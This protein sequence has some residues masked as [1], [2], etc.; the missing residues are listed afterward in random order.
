MYRRRLDAHDQWPPVEPSEHIPLLLSENISSST[1]TEEMIEN[2][3]RRSLVGNVAST[4]S[5]QRHFTINQLFEPTTLS[6]PEIKSVLIEGAPGIGKTAL[7][8]AACQLWAQG[9]VFQHFKMVIRWSLSS[10]I[11]AGVG[12]VNDLIFHDSVA[13][14]LAVVDTVCKSGGKGVLYVLD[15][16]DEL[17]DSVDE[18][19]VT[20][21]LDLVKGKRL[22]L[23]CV[24]VTTRPLQSTK[25]YKLKHAWFD[26]IVEISGFSEQ[27]IQEYISK[28]LSR[29]PALATK[30]LKQLST[31]PDIESICYI[32]L[33]C[34][35]VTY[36]FSRKQLLPK[37]LSEFYKVF[38]LNFLL[39]NM[40]ERLEGGSKIDELGH[41]DC[42]PTPVKKI[43]VGISELAFR[44]LWVSKHMYSRKEFESVF[45][46]S[47]VVVEVDQLGVLQTQTVFH[48]T[49]S[50][51]VF[52]FL[53]SSVQEYLAACYLAR[54]STGEQ[55]LYISKYLL[56]RPLS[57]VWPF[58]SGVAS[59]ITQLRE[60]GFVSQFSEIAE[61]IDSWM[62]YRD[63]F[64][65]ESSLCS[66]YESETDTS[67]S[68]YG[69]DNTPGLEPIQSPCPRLG[70]SCSSLASCS[71]PLS[72]PSSLAI[73]SVQPS[74]AVTTSA[75][76]GTTFLTTS[77]SSSLTSR[78][79]LLSPPSSVVQDSN[80]S[81][82]RIGGS[83]NR[84][85]YSRLLFVLKCLF[86]SQN[87]ALC[88]VVAEGLKGRISLCGRALQRIDIVTIGYFL[89]AVGK[90]FLVKIEDCK[91]RKH[92]LI[93]LDH[94]LKNAFGVIQKLYLG[95]NGLDP[96]SAKEL[97]KMAPTLSHCRTLVLRKNELG[98]EGAEY[99][100]DMLGNLHQ[101]QA[102]D[103]S[104]NHI[105]HVGA[106]HICRSLQL[107]SKLTH[108]H[109]DHN[110][111]GPA[112]AKQIAQAVLDV[113][114][115]QHLSIACTEL[116]DRGVEALA[117]VLGE[118]G[119]LR[120]LDISGNGIT[121]EGAALLGSALTVNSSLRILKFHSNLIG[122]A[123]I[124]IIF[125]ALEE[126]KSLVYLDANSCVISNEPAF[127]NAV[128]ALAQNT[129]LNKLDISYNRLGDDGVASVVAAVSNTTSSVFHLVIAGNSMG[130]MATKTLASKLQQTTKLTAVTVSASD[131]LDISHEVAF[132][133][134]LDA[135]T[136]TEG[137]LVLKINTT[138]SQDEH[139]QLEPCFQAI[140]EQRKAL[141]LRK[142]KVSFVDAEESPE[143]YVTDSEDEYEEI[144]EEYEIEEEIEESP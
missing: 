89:A 69:E 30:L 51:V 124:E 135:L 128:N 25:A 67:E 93:T 83:S 6:Q 123:G 57:S 79:P 27:N 105:S 131:L 33:N 143:Q 22:P 39:R 38:I 126:N 137:P 5:L 10:L 91:I 56:Y 59:G 45:H 130:V 132:Q 129:S 109:L 54:L 98:D 107:S 4:S 13:K 134:L 100:S 140:N 3:V 99:V 65:L 34:A 144:I 53:H 42:L 31:R 62:V 64:S 85:L 101:L 9:K 32:P 36:V 138:G 111:F 95:E 23:A 40:Q 77:I 8:Y 139:D 72:S 92:H 113:N 52:H 2:K 11:S 96:A 102:L 71:V 43:F 110:P 116:G 97:S 142:I 66:D 115:L 50:S 87:K 82:Q 106:Q 86:E 26:R 81:I 55:I 61:D 120:H 48:S 18:R 21:L 63:I 118:N 60:T 88:S 122:A 37:T 47:N 49:G 121:D 14:R 127:G 75:L 141:S 94:Q 117:A 20:A 119:T 125:S 136:L 16:W 104:A 73:S 29:E 12:C 112:P 19:I 70:L 103:L 46:S 114:M 44:G 133:S 17:P 84:W 74:A 15:G 78:N 1:D 68:D 76:P 58:Y 108:L 24:L 90:P 28:A 35:I 41:L 7:T 80:I